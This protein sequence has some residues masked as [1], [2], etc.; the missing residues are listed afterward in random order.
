MNIHSILSTSYKEPRAVRKDLFIQSVTVTE[1]LKQEYPVS[2]TVSYGPLQDDT[3]SVVDT[4]W[5]TTH[6]KGPYTICGSICAS[7][8]SEL[9]VLY[10]S[11]YTTV[12]IDTVSRQWRPRSACA[13][14][15][16]DLGLYCPKIAQEPFSCVAHHVF[17]SYIQSRLRW[18]GQVTRMPDERLPKK[19]L[20][21][22]LEVGKRS[23]G[24]QKK[25]YKDTLKAS[26][27]RLQHTNRVVGTECT[28]SNKV[29]RPHKKVN[30]KQK[31]SAKPSRN[32]HSGKPELRPNFFL[33]QTS[34]VLSATGSLEQRLVSA[35]IL[36]HT[37]NNTSHSWLWLVIVSNDRRTTYKP[38]S[39]ICIITKTCLFKYTEKFTTKKW[40]L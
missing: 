3:A 6:E 29:A 37:N 27:Q 28:G 10:S 4:T 16:A 19:I 23:H 38:R 5:C 34:L 31:D 1:L 18:T 8:Q 15:Q 11:T 25:L 24:G 17:F 12:A 14:A 20:Y 30:T 39:I 21:G 32:V 2:E 33:P 9:S 36:E 40:K 13:Y 7:M 22:E 26:L 35:A